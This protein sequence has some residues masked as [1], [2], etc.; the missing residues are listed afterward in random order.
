LVA[1]KESTMFAFVKSISAAANRLA[2]S[3]QA[4]AASVDEINEGL[5]L[6]VGLDKPPRKGR[7][8]EHKPATDGK[9]AEVA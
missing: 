9:P 4:L 7:A 5:R 8:L 2:K 1:H 3:L 6:Q